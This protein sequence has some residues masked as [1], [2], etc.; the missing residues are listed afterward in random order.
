MYPRPCQHHRSTWTATSNSTSLVR[1]LQC[2]NQEEQCWTNISC[3]L[4]GLQSRQTTLM[5]KKAEDTLTTQE[6]Y[7]FQRN[8]ETQT[9]RLSKTRDTASLN[10]HVVGQTH[11]K[12]DAR[13]QP[14]R[15]QET[16][17]VRKC[18]NGVTSIVLPIQQIKSN[19]Y[20]VK[21]HILP[22]RRS[23]STKR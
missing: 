11:L 1:H 16:I 7:G 8:V 13:S 3:L 19:V 12:R 14:A 9:T 4:S 6:D 2:H 5:P 23:L 10:A 18:R 20:T 21:R 17:V 22:R 15:S